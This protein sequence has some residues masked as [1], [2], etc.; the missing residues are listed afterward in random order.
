MVERV[1]Y[2]LV[3]GA[4]SANANHLGTKIERAAGYVSDKISAHVDDAS[5]I[6]RGGRHVSMLLQQMTYIDMIIQSPVRN[7]ERCLHT[8]LHPGLDFLTTIHHPSSSM[9]SLLSGSITHQQ[10][11]WRFLSRTSHLQ[12]AMFAGTDRFVCEGFQRTP[13]RLLRTHRTGARR[14][15]R[16]REPCAAARRSWPYR[17][18]RGARQVRRFFLSCLVCL[19]K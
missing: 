7:P 2:P 1:C 4:I 5:K 9:T 14:S 10:Q 8:P 15:T 16:D 17:A 19:F 11:S 12:F 18:L 6:Y 13:S 3:L